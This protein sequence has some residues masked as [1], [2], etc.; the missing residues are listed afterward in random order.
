[1]IES[2][3]GDPLASQAGALA[4]L[5]AELA[6]ESVDLAAVIDEVVRRIGALGTHAD[7]LCGGDAGQ[8]NAEREAGYHT[9]NQ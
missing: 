9:F 3:V 6:L 1:M 7:G 5:V 8:R 4:Q 2:F